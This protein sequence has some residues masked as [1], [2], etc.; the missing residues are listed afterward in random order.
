VSRENVCPPGGTWYEYIALLVT[1]QATAVG[2]ATIV[3]LLLSSA[4]RD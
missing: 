4:W 3:W 2:L 1:M